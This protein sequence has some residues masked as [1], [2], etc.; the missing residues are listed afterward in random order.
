MMLVTGGAGFI[1]SHLVERLIHDG[2]QVRVLDNFS[3]GKASN[4]DHLRREVEVIEGDLRDSDVTRRAMAGIDVV[5]H[6]AAVPSVPRSIADPET[7]IDVNTRGTLG[8]LLA[9]RDVGCRRVV[10]ASSSSVYGDTPELPK[11]ETMTPNPLSP[12]AV[13]KLSAEQLCRVFTNVY[14]LETVALRYFNVFGPRQDPTSQYSAV[15]PKFLA[16]LKDGQTSIVFGDGEQSRD[17]TYVENVVHANLCASAAE[18]A[19][20]Q[21]FNVASGRAVTVIQ[22]L[23]MLAE[24]LE[25]TPLVEYAPQRPGEVRDSLAD[26]SAARNVLGYEVLVPFE[27]GLR[28]TVE[29]VREGAPF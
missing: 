25:V 17:F 19:A 10:F 24:L 9:A 1:G 13:S 3:S 16:A 5:F 12:Y 15:I 29:S 21:V 28:R 14:G 4:L 20:G 7:A 2:A 18:A 26:I 11:R 6:L 8:L 23:R 27:E 22:M